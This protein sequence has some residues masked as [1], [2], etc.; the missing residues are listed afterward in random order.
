MYLHASPLQ[1][2]NEVLVDWAALSRRSHEGALTT[3]PAQ[4]LLVAL[5]AQ[6]STRMKRLR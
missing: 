4:D 3:A 6:V 2:S 1:Q 5:Y